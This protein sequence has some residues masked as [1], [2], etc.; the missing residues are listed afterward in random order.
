MNKSY[1]SVWNET[2]G[3][4]VAASEVT[5]SRSKSSASKKALAIAT[6][7]TLGALSGEAAATENC[8]TADGSGG[9]TDASGA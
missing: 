4:Y 1:K 3:T 5:K 2:T 7:V 8:T 6:F 9:T